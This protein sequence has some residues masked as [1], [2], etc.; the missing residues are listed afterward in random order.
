MSSILLEYSQKMA[1]IL[2]MLATHKEAYYGALWQVD[3]VIFGIS[4]YSILVDK[5][6][7]WTAI[8]YSITL[9]EHTCSSTQFMFSVAYVA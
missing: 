5:Q 7:D 9:I 3:E 8:S 4:I 2:I 1:Y 6:T